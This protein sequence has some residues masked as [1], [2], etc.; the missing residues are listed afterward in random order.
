MR[1]IGSGGVATGGVVAEIADAVAVLV[2]IRIE[3]GVEGGEGDSALIGAEVDGGV[4]DA[5]VPSPSSQ[6]HAFRKP[7][8]PP[9][10]PV[11]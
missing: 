2:A 11:A 9:D 1:V 8:S 4:E 5:W 3:A 10:Q 6:L 7:T